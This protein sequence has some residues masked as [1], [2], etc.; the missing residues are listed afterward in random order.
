LSYI[1]TFTGID[2]YVKSYSEDDFDIVDIAHALSNNCRWAG[3]TSSFYS[4]AQHSVYV[5]RFMKKHKMLG[6]IHDA[7]EAYGSDMPTPFK[8]EL[9]DFQKMETRMQNKIYNK[10]LG[11]LPSK[12]AHEQLKIADKL[13]LDFEGTMF[14]K[15]WQN[16]IDVSIIKQV[17]DRFHPWEPR[18]ARE[19]FLKEFRKLIA[20][21]E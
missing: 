1:T 2:F 15:H 5:S 17:D 11:A 16:I 10:F 4:V 8:A 20:T 6:L 3:H 14:I 12:E 19:E 7:S 9:P 13:L 18:H 21:E